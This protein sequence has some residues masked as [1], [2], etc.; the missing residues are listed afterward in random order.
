[1]RAAVRREQNPVTAAANARA[2]S[3][4]RAAAMALKPKIRPIQIQ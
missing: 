4:R 1:M 2:T 3:P